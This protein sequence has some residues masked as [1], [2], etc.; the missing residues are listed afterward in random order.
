MFA[1]LKGTITQLEPAFA[2]VEC[3]G[4][5]Y[6]AMISLNTHD[7]LEGKKEVKLFTHLQVREDSHTLYGFADLQ[8]QSL[9]E[10]L[11]TISGVG[12]NTALTIL[13]SLSAE[14]LFQAISMEDTLTLKRVK[15]IGAK[16]AGRIVLEL[17]DKIKLE[18]EAAGAGRS[19]RKAS[20]GQ[21]KAEAIA[22]LGQLG[23]AKAEMSKRI[24]RILKEVDKDDLSV[25]KLVKMALRNPG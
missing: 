3:G 5:G 4:V 24:D 15:G 7:L 2:I 22:A 1:Y 11:I 6:R 13:S 19:S 10:Q 25:E 8:E 12:A 9:F 20:A 21:L 17:K 23:F 18:V 14:E 16:T